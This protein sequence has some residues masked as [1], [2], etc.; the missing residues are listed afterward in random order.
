LKPK[1]ILKLCQ[2]N[3]TSNRLCKDDYFWKKKIEYDYDVAGF[4]DD[5]YNHYKT[6]TLRCGDLYKIE[7]YLGVK[8]DVFIMKNIRKVWISNHHYYI[9][10]NNNFYVEKFRKHGSNIMIDDYTT[11]LIFDHNKDLT[12]E[13]RP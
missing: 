5:N 4:D 1:E 7:S 3:K 9:D 6:L 13:W 10:H 8:T 2:T 11:K 12:N